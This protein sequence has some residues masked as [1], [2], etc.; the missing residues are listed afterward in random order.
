ME[1]RWGWEGVL[2]SSLSTHCA[3][4]GMKKRALP[5]A[6]AQRERCRCGQFRSDVEPAVLWAWGRVLGVQAAPA[7][8]ALA[9]SCHRAPSLHIDRKKALRRR[10]TVSCF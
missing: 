6:A 7:S 1:G 2:I 3:S 10:N 8:E 4:M 9:Q 5:C